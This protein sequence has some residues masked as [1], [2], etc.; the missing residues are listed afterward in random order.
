MVSRASFPTQAIVR[1]A[2]AALSKFKRRVRRRS[3]PRSSRLAAGT[4]RDKRW[5][6]GKLVWVLLPIVLK[7]YHA[8][9]FDVVRKFF[10]NLLAR[11]FLGD[12]RRL[13]VFAAASAER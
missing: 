9:V 8:E 13:A 2:K 7:E 10:E 1:S 4:Q 12:S 5:S 6:P 11:P 3:I